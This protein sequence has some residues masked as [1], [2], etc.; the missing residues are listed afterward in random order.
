MGYSIPIDK[1]K[2]FIICLAYRPLD[3]SLDCFD[4]EL[5]EPFSSAF[6]LSK[7]RQVIAMP[8]PFRTS[9]LPSI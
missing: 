5:S 4:Q 3:C 8:E 2:S 7:L 9:A 6:M 1:H